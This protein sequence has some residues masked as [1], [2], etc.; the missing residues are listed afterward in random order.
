MTRRT[1]NG[2]PGNGKEFTEPARE[3]PADLSQSDGNR[4]H[5]AAKY[6]ARAVH[7]VESL[8]AR[9]DEIVMILDKGHEAYVQD[10]LLQRAMEGCA[11]R[12]GDTI[13]NK[14]PKALQEE[15]GGKEEWSDWVAWR[16]QIAHHY[17]AVSHDRVWREAARDVPVFRRYLSVDVLGDS[18]E[19]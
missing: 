15:F 5:L 16:V 19:A 1:D 14:I 13:R 4:A 18:A 3:D 9:L 7:E 8:V 11:N 17:T 12:I 6:G 10:V 2:M